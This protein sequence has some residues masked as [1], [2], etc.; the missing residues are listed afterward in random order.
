MIGMGWRGGGLRQSSPDQGRAAGGDPGWGGQED[1]A[2]ATLRRRRPPLW[3]PP[4]HANLPPRWK[5]ADL[6]VYSYARGPLE[7][8][9]VLSYARD[10]VNDMDFPIEWVVE[11]GAGRTYSSTYGHYWHDQDNP[12]GCVMWPSRT[13]MIRPCNGWRSSLSPQ[14]CP[15]TS[16]R[17][18]PS[19]CKMCRPR[20]RDSL[21]NRQ[22]P[23]FVASALE[24]HSS[25]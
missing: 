3:R 24:R 14:S 20:S 8:L 5:S 17:N 1:P 11:Y 9:T 2:R 16:R 12:P 23:S 7:N 22:R 25:K 21:S 13:L 10:P 19:P 18:P 6:E 15:P 4:I